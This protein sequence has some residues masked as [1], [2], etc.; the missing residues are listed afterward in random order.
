MPDF[1]SSTYSRYTGKWLIGTGIFELI[2]A[3]GFLVLGVSEPILTFGFGLTAAILGI[4]GFALVWF[5]IRARRSASEADRLTTTGIAG[6]ATITGLTQTGMSLNNQPQVGIDLE[7]SILGRA[8][9]AA[10]RKEFV[11]L[12]LLGR[13]S[14]GSALPVKVDPADPQSLVIDWSAPTGEPTSAFSGWTSPVTGS[15]VPAGDTG[16]L[17]QVEAALAASGLPAARQT[18]ALAKVQAALAAQGITTTGQTETLA[19]VQAALAASGLP[20]AGA[21]ATSEQGGYGVDQVRA[22]VRATGID[23]TAT[24]DTLR[25]TGKTVG[26]ERVFS[27]GVTLHVPGRPDRQLQPA[28][29]A[30]P[31]AAVDKVA[32]GRTVPVKVA[33]DNPDVIVFEWERLDAD[34]RPKAPGPPTLV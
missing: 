28:A 29:A 22:M 10:H 31:I 4:T 33:S 6:T 17:G 7:V 23:G 30:V 27:M 26:D 5:G 20:A 15:T 2:L 3:A 14:S 12:I 8:P 25:D 24:I 16:M 32:V 11:P 13:L 19:Q 34:G 18:E 1:T 9:Y 21:Y